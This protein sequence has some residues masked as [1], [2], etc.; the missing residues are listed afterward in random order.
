MLLLY[1][2]LWER[3]SDLEKDAIGAQ[4]WSSVKVWS[5]LLL[6]YWAGTKGLGKNPNYVLEEMQHHHEL[7]MLT[8]YN[9]K[10]VEIKGSWSCLG[11]ASVCS[12]PLRPLQPL[13]TSTKLPPYSLSEVGYHS[14]TDISFSGIM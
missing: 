1:K 2:W 4:G 8:L 9:Q 7:K 5:G 14:H 6:A 12:S 10:V 3:P 11:W 13:G